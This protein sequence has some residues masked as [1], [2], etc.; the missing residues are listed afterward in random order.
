MLNATVLVQGQLSRT[1]ER[2]TSRENSTPYVTAG[3]REGLGEDVRWW[4]I[5]AFGD[6]ADELARLA[7]GDSVAVTGSLTVSIYEKNGESRAGL[8]VMVFRLVSVHRQKRQPERRPD[9]L[10]PTTA[11][12]FRDDPL[13][14]EAG[15]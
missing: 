2:R 4:S 6:A 10:P 7:V 12:P 9:R 13:S 1:P 15:Q 14:Q 5:V 11:K 8:A 3:L